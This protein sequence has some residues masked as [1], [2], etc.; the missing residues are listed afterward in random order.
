MMKKI[1]SEIAKNGVQA[2]AQ[3]LQSD[4]PDRDKF[5]CFAVI[6]LVKELADKAKEF[7]EIAGQLDKKCDCLRN[8]FDNITDNEKRKIISERLSGIVQLC[9]GFEQ[10]AE[11]LR[12]E[13]RFFSKLAVQ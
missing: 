9:D 3:M 1:N 5:N 12:N 10:L 4:E 2:T 8:E 6:K 13:A 7:S 11:S